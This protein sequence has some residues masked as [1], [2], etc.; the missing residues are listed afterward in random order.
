MGLDIATTTAISGGVAQAT[1]SDTALNFDDT[2]ITVAEMAA[3][4]RAIVFVRSG[5]INVYY[6]GTAPTTSAG[7]KFNTDDKFEILNSVDIG[8]FQMI[9]NGSTDAVVDIVLEN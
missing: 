8:N 4:A 1:V 3:A 7:L 6:D 2:A 5:A 9:R